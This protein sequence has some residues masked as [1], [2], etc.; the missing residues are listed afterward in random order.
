MY[1]INTRTYDLIP[2]IRIPLRICIKRA[3]IAK[4]AD[5]SA[6]D[7][8]L[9]VVPLVHSTSQPFSAKVFFEVV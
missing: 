2:V 4:A 3:A 8:E 6:T 9:N 7:I 1:D 5:L